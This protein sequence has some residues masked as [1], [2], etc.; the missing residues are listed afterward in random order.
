MKRLAILL[1]PCAFALAQGQQTNKTEVVVIRGK[2]MGFASVS[3]ALQKEIEAKHGKKPAPVAN[4]MG[5]NAQVGKH[6]YTY[7]SP[8]AEGKGKKNK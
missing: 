8:S 3:P 1:L 5:P 6:G 2:V 4:A 7:V